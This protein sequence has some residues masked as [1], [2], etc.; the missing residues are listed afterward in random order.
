MTQLENA[1]PVNDIWICTSQSCVWCLCFCLSV[2]YSAARSTVF[3]GVIHTY[4]IVI[5]TAK[6]N[7]FLWRNSNGCWNRT[8]S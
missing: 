3:A 2:Y 4:T 5:Y 7:K 6:E 8:P 1:Q